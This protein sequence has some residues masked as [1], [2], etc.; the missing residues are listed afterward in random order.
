MPSLWKRPDRTLVTGIPLMIQ[1]LAVMIPVNKTAGSRTR[2]PRAPIPRCMFLF[3]PY[4]RMQ[5][6]AATPI[7]EEN[8]RAVGLKA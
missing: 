7:R 3:F 1:V 5:T 6:S 2:S 8:T 4:R